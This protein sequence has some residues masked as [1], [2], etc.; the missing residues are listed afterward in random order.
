MDADAMCCRE[1]LPRTEMPFATEKRS[2]GRRCHVL[3]RSSITDGD[4]ICCT[5]AL[6]WTGMPFA[7]EK[8]YRGWECHL[9]Q[10]SS[11]VG[12]C[13][14]HPSCT[15]TSNQENIGT[16]CQTNFSNRQQISV[17]RHL[18]CRAKHVA[19]NCNHIGVNRHKLAQIGRR[20]QSAHFDF[21]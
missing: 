2:R 15:H 3:Q 11:L 13:H 18:L 20:C 12:N 6:S 5:E 14:R 21:T 17:D 16:N 9:L 8:L 19:C 1:A 7:A 4:A 10:R